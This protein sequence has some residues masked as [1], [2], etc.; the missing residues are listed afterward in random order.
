MYIFTRNKKVV[1]LWSQKMEFMFLH[2]FS[3]PVAIFPGIIY[4]W[5]KRY[6]WYKIFIWDGLLLTLPEMVILNMRALRDAMSGKGK[7]CI[8]L[9]Y[10][11]RRLARVCQPDTVP[12][13]NIT[14]LSLLSLQ[15][16]TSI[17][18]DVLLETSYLCSQKTSRKIY[19]SC[20]IIKTRARTDWVKWVFL[21]RVGI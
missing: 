2:N 6:C 20:E 3:R 11:C 8:Y 19:S 12:E 14:R 17:F 7:L 10:S 4:H 9:S 15:T 16:R 13:G 18:L 5:L 1:I 21:S